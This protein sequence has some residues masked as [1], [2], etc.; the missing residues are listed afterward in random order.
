MGAKFVWRMIEGKKEW[1]KEALRKKY[2][3]KPRSHCIDHKWEEQGTCIWELCKALVVVIKYMGYWIPRNG[4]KKIW[5]DRIWYQP[6]LALD[7]NLEEFR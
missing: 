5:E 3:E 4:K 6:N 2:V 7:P 1:W